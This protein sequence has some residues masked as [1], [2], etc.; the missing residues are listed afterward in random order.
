MFIGGD[1]LSPLLLYAL[2][3]TVWTPP[4]NGSAIEQPHD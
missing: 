2:T 4:E 1:E 3:T